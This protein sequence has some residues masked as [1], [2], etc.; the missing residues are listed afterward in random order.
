MRFL[1][2][3]YRKRVSEVFFVF[4]DIKVIKRWNFVFKNRGI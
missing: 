1:K 4:K 3:L 2:E